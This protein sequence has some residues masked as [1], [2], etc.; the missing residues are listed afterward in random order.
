MIIIK[1]SS[2]NEGEWKIFFE[3]L[4][5]EK[6]T[7]LSENKNSLIECLEKYIIESIFSTLFRSRIDLMEQDSLLYEK[8]LKMKEMPLSS[9]LI[10]F[11]NAD[12]LPTFQESQDFLLSLNEK[13]TPLEKIVCISKT[14]ISIFHSL[15]LFHTQLRNQPQPHSREEGESEKNLQE[16]KK[17][18]FKTNQPGESKK[19]ATNPQNIQQTERENKEEKKKEKTEYK[20]TLGLVEIQSP[21]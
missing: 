18:L 10:D 11:Q 1:Q 14:C 17:N 20:G 3:G 6:K 8:I 16:D 12:K 5:V 4:N 19:E 21:L 15:E 7:D 13:K 2:T 9:F